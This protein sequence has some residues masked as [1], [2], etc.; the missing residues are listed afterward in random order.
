MNRRQRWMNVLRIGLSLLTLGFLLVQVGGHKVWAVVKS[1]RMDILGVAWGLF[2]LG[3]LIRVFRWRALLQGLDIYPSFWQLLKLYL[4]GGFFNTF[5]PSGFGGDVVRVLELSQDADDSAAVGTVLVD[6]LTGILS[7]MALGLLMLPFARDL[8]PWLVWAFVVIS[9]GGLLAGFLLLE[10]RFLRTVT[11]HLPGSLSLMGQNKLAQVYDAVTGC[12]ARAIWLA[13]LFSTLFNLSNIA[14]YWLCG[15]AVGI[16]VGLDFYFI[17]TPLLSLTLLIPISVGGLGA[18]DWV[19]QPLF[20]SAGIASE[21]SAGMT[22]AVY[23]VTAVAGLIGG[24]LYL[25]QGIWGLFQKS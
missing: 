9:G 25:G 19:A 11:A 21:V 12:G 1:A 23:A 7:L 24:A 10:G 22:L 3:I 2:L 18:R 5:L 14:V 16:S 8:V 13:L 17:V 20:G 4:V 15:L 6:R